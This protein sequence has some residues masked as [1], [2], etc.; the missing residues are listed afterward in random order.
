MTVAVE[1]RDLSFSY[2]DGRTAL[3]NVSF[4][5]Q[6]GE[7]VGLIGPNGAGKSTLLQHLNGLL[8][9][10]FGPKPE[11]SVFGRPVSA[12]TLHETHRDVGFLFQDPD[13]QLFCPTVFDDVAFGP[14]Q[15][16]EPAADVARKVQEALAAVGLPDFGNRVPHHLSAGEKQRACLAGILVCQPRLLV[17]DEPSSSLDPRGKRGLIGLLQ[18]L[19]VTKIIASHDLELVVSL[20]SRAILLDAGRLVADGPARELLAD[21]KLMLEHGL[22]TP[23]SLRHPH[24]H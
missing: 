21:E 5:V 1:V 22:E 10:S 4:T 11:V 14:Q 16:G 24:P 6:D 19:P 18:A 2:H 8:P 17:L 23:H 15:F 12:E 20:C 3:R 13:D 7:C 9:E